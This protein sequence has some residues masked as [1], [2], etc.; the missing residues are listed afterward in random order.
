MGEGE[1]SVGLDSR[2]SYPAERRRKGGGKRGAGDRE[3]ERVEGGEGKRKGRGGGERKRKEGEERGARGGKRGGE[4]S[5]RRGK[6]RGGKEREEKRRGGKGKGERGG[7]E[8]G[9]GYLLPPDDYLLKERLAPD[10]QLGLDASSFNVVRLVAPVGT[11]DFEVPLDILSVFDR[12]RV[13]KRQRPRLFTL[14]VDGNV[15]LVREGTLSS[16]LM[17]LP[18]NTPP[19][20][21]PSRRGICRTSPLARQL[22]VELSKIS[23]EFM[24]L[25]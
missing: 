18:K 20:P 1:Q 24:A 9:S 12:E 22:L 14:K 3:P 16:T 25:R 6:R 23:V 5:E 13:R 4:G 11:I 2:L 17:I 15:V 21:L 7:E 8:V 19:S 10:R